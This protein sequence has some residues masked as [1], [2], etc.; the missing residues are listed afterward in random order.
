MTPSTRRSAEGQP[1]EEQPS[2]RRPR[3]ATAATSGR[4]RGRAPPSRGR[5]EPRRGTAPTHRRRQDAAGALRGRRA[6]PRRATPRGPDEPAAAG[7]PEPLGRGPTPSRSQSRPPRSRPRP[8]SPRPTSSSPKKVAADAE[9]AS[10]PPVAGAAGTPRGRGAARSPRPPEPLHHA[11]PS[12]ATASRVVRAQAKYAHPR[13]W[14]ASCATPHPRQVGAGGARDPRAHP[15]PRGARPG[16]SCVDVRRSPRRAQPRADRRRPASVSP[17]PPTR[18]P[19][20]K[21]FRP[22]AMGRAT[23]IRK[24]TSHLTITLTP[25]E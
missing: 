15:P 1:A 12:A 14:P 17:S 2:S 9:T 20:L 4:G 21:R 7:E 24:R 8:T 3:P 23:R 13:A 18:G 25:K 10:P 6:E 5:A 19:T 22:R 11:H 16:A